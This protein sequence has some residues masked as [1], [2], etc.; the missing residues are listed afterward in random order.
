LIRKFGRELVAALVVLASILVAAS[1]SRADPLIFDYRGFH[2]DLSG[3]RGAMAD[4]KMIAAVKRQIDIV[5]QMKLKPDVIAFMRTVKIWANPKKTGLG[6]GHYARATGVDLQMDQ[7]DT[8]RPILLHELLHAYHDQ[9]L[10]NGFANKDIQTFYE[11]GRS[12][13]WPSDS[14]LMSNHREFF[15]VSASVYLFGDIPRP[16]ESRK[17]LREKQP[18]YYQWLADLFDGGKPRS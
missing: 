16:P 18:Q 15:A 8:K 12:A 10:P 13:G 14:Y 17:Q 7:L 11:R 2:V 6:P 4:A 9:Q 1:S 3:A 5:E